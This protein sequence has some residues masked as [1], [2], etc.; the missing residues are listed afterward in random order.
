[1]PAASDD[2][3]RGTRLGPP[4]RPTDRI[5][6]PGRGGDL[7]AI[8][9]TR[10]AAVPDVPPIDEPLLTEGLEP[11]DSPGADA[12]ATGHTAEA[13]ARGGVEPAPSSPVTVFDQRPQDRPSG[14]ASRRGPPV[15]GSSERADA[16]RD[17]RDSYVTM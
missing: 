15:T 10:G 3:S 6:F 13:Q 2:L 4:I 17:V 16:I 14:V 5:V 1:M 12:R 9:R 8:D 7:W 11:I